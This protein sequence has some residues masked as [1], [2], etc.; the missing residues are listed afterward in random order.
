MRRAGAEHGGPAGA[1][2]AIQTC[3]R[4][5]TPGPG[6]AHRA[7]FQGRRRLQGAFQ[8]GSNPGPG[9]LDAQSG[10][11]SESDQDQ[12]DVTQRGPV[13]STCRS[14]ARATST[15]MSGP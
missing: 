15:G 8:N 4:M 14:S 10:K 12:Y 6:D 5:R 2:V 9:L 11:T 1:C 3:E 13:K 7:G